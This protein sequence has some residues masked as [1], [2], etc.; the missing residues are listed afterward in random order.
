YAFHLDA[1]RPPQGDV[2][3][4]VWGVPD[5]RQ[6]LVLVVKVSEDVKLVLPDGTTEGPRVLLIRVRQHPV[7]DRIRPGPLAVAEVADEGPRGRV[8]SGFRHGVHL[9]TG[10]PALRRVEAVRDELEF[11]NCVLAVARLI[12]DAELRGHLL[13]VNVQLELPDVAG[14]TVLD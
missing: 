13:A 6:R 9:H 11:R 12:A 7:K 8:R 14:M 1:L 4:R 3:H 2:E 5:R 10:G